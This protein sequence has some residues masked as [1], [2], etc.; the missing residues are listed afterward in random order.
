MLFLAWLQAS[1][2]PKLDSL[3][4]LS[5]A[6]I[7]FCKTLVDVVTANWPG[8][9]SWLPI[10]AV[11]IL[12]PCVVALLEVYLEVSLTVPTIAG[13]VLGGWLA[14]AGA[15]TQTALSNQAKAARESVTS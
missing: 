13:C 7:P 10:V 14:G 4:I 15:I 3:M 1:Q 11:G 6:A 12:G 8:R 2:P 5:A 9:P